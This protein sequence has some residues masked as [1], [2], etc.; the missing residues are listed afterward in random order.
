MKAT[1]IYGLVDPR[2]EQIRYIGK[3]I[4]P[5]RRLYQ[6][7]RRAK[8]NMRSYTHKTRWLRQLFSENVEPK[9]IILEECVSSKWEE[10]EMHWI[11]TLDNL[12]N[13]ASGG[14]GIDVPRTPEWCKRISESN[15]GRVVSKE[16]R[17]KLRQANLGKRKGYFKCGH[18]YTPKNTWE[19]RNGWRC[20]WKCK[21]ESVRK[22]LERRRRKQG[23]KPRSSTHCKRGHLLSGENLKMR[24]RVANGKTYYCRECRECIRIRNREYKKR[25]RRRQCE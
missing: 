17:E 10:R 18:S 15:K 6:H 16:C 24:K 22:S 23:I 20:C 1:Y 21:R 14:Q 7:I 25:K 9:M 3:T 12:V 11:A 2:T 19:D 4:D 8:R 5:K 13:I